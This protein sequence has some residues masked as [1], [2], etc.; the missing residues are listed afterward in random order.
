MPTAEPVGDPLAAPRAESEQPGAAHRIVTGGCTYEGT[1][2]EI[3]QQMRDDKSRDLPL[4]QYMATEARRGYGMTGIE[5][6]ARDPE[7]FIKGSANAGLLRI[8]S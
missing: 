7:S 6:S 2:E 4:D 8:D 5:I 3:V 1:W